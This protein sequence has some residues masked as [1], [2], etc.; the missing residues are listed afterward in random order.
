MGFMGIER[1]G[2]GHW[3]VAVFHGPRRQYSPGLVLLRQPDETWEVL[4]EAGQIG[5]P[6][7]AYGTW[8]SERA[9]CQEALRLLRSRFGEGMFPC[10]GTGSPNRVFADL[11][12]K[13]GRARWRWWPPGLTSTGEIP[14]GPDGAPAQSGPPAA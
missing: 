5:P 7:I 10:W 11:G 9:A 6:D 13:R 4:D 1:D 14:V 8:P 3:H 12:Y 2:E